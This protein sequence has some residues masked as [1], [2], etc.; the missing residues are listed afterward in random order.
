MPSI[1][2]NNKHYSFDAIKHNGATL[3]NDNEGAYKFSFTLAQSWLNDQEQF[4][5]HTSGSTG[6]PK[7]ISLLRKQLEASAYGTIEAL[8]L[9]S[10]EH[11]LVCMNTQFI[12]GAMLLIRGLIL[13]AT[14]TLH[15]PSNYPLHQI[16]INHPYTFVSFAPLQV[17]SIL[18]NADHE[19]EKLNGFRNILIGGAAIDPSLE[20][21]LNSLNAYVY[22][23]YGMTETVS[24]IAL[25]E[26]GKRNY[27]TILNGVSIKTDDRNC[28]AIKSEST[29]NNWIQTNDVV[30]LINP[31]SFIIL[32]RADD[33]IN[34]GGI[35]IFPGKIEDAIRISSDYITNVFVYGIDDIQL[36]Q[37]LIAVI[38]AKNWNILL[39]KELD[40]ELAQSLHKYEIPKQ[41]Y[42]LPAFNYTQSGKT[43]KHETLKM[44]DL[45]K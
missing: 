2:V 41:F 10:A 3:L 17:F 21:S 18:K 39:Q 1:I 9:T 32:G 15:E 23:T 28:L 22:H 42:I 45:D 44:I 5:F 26:L 36:G 33:I 40:S 14:I 13:G 34:S 6:T 8:S 27:F 37:K 25:K 12:G 11:I 16:E 35:K 31:T 24:H 29:N 20:A 19:I 38:E 43:N 30:E 4:V 7:E